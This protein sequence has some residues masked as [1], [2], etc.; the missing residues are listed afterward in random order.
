MWVYDLGL[1]LHFLDLAQRSHSAQPNNGATQSHFWFIFQYILFILA[2]SRFSVVWHSCKTIMIVRVALC[3]HHP[4]ARHPAARSP[5]PCFWSL[6]RAASHSVGLLLAPPCALLH[7]APAPPPSNAEKNASMKVQHFKY[8][9][10]D[11]NFN[12]SS[13]QFQ[14]LNIKCLNF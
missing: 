11:F 5:T 10:Y 6:A 13:L 14:H 9:I 12:I 7:H 4:E 1:G 8:N 3:R 2:F